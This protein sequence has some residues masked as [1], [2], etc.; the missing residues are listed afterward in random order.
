MKSLDTQIHANVSQ[1]YS[2]SPLQSDTSD[3]NDEP[4]YNICGRTRCDA[5]NT[6]PQIDNIVATNSGPKSRTTQ[7]TKHLNW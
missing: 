6:T 4:F 7:Y 5:Q 1:V 3:R 2:T